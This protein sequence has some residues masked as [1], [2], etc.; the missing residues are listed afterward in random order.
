MWFHV[1]G[2]FSSF[3]KLCQ[4]T[5]HKFNT[6][7]SNDLASQYEHTVH[8]LK[9]IFS[10]K[11]TQACAFRT[12]VFSTFFYPIIRTKYPHAFGVELKLLR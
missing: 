3:L 11:H 7:D 5:Y 4:I 1:T 8:S 12:S 6:K 2:M 10:V 9:C